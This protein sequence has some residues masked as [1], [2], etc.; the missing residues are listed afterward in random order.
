MDALGPLF[1]N[2]ASIAGPQVV[3]GFPKTN[4]YL[5][6]ENHYIN[7][8]P[9]NHAYVIDIIERYAMNH[10]DVSITLATE[11]TP[12]SVKVFVENT[13]LNS[14]LSALAREFHKH[15]YLPKNVSVAFADIRRNAPFSLLESIYDFNSFAFLYRLGYDE[16]RDLYSESKIFER[17]FYENTNTTEKCI[18]L[19]KSLILP[20]M[21][22]PPWY[23]LALRKFKIPAR[24]ELKAMMLHVHNT[25]KT[26]YKYISKLISQ[27]LEHMIASHGEYSEAMNI[28]EQTRRTESPNMVGQKYAHLGTFWVAVNA[29]LTDIYIIGLLF[30][31]IQSKPDPKRLFI[32]LTGVNHTRSL[33]EAINKTNSVSAFSKDGILKPGDITTTPTIYKLADSPGILL[34]KFKK[35]HHNKH[36][37]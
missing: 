24:N 16:A 28:A 22:V 7:G 27:K 14:P 20:D 17:Q 12:E 10:P 6:G 21:E 36:N 8:D 32:A 25:N 18:T 15:H 11:L 13:K 2:I 31:N 3:Y 23:L 4:I 34:K 29:I 9:K 33:Y 30:S 37:P 26:V 5:L 1:E 19:F 35:A